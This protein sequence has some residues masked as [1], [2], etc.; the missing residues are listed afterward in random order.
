[1]TIAFNRSHAAYLILATGISAADRVAHNPLCPLSRI[2]TKHPVV[3][4]RLELDLPQFGDLAVGAVGPAGYV[5]DRD[6]AAGTERIDA[7]EVPS[8]DFLGVIR[9][10][11]PA[12]R[13]GDVQ[14]APAQLGLTVC[15]RTVRCTP[16][17]LLMTGSWTPR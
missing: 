3:E 14:C 17:A 5:V 9:P 7:D 15:L 10:L 13:Y 4:K 11:Q 8:L 12:S 16:D 2:D 1:M 6:D